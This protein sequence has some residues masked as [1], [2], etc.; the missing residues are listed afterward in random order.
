VDKRHGG[1]IWTPVALTTL[2]AIFDAG[3]DKV[4]GVAEVHAIL[5]GHVVRV[6][7]ADR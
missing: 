3:I 6:R 2:M 7:I 4:Q 1:I 5:D